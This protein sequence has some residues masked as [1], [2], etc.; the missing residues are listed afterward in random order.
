[1]ILV[2][3][4]ERRGN[5]S[6]FSSSSGGKGKNVSRKEWKKGELVTFNSPESSS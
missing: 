2:R 1:M 5:S 4:E 6:H 3:E